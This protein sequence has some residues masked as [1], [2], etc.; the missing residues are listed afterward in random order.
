MSSNEKNRSLKRIA[1]VIVLAAAAAALAM[2]FLPVAVTDVLA[3]TEM[4]S[5]ESEAE[6]RAA[7]EPDRP[8]TV[9]VTRALSRV[10]NQSRAVAG[11]VEPARTVDIAFQIPGQVF[12]LDVEAGDR[13]LKGDVI[14]KLDQADFELAV[15]R[16]QASF[17]LAKTEFDRASSLAQR[18]VAADARLDTARAQFAQADVALRESTRRLSQTQIT[19][20]FDAI[21]A[22]TFVEEYVNVTSAAPV[23]RLQDVSEMRI[24]ISLPEEL[25]AVAR[26]SPDA[27]DI[28][29]SFPAVPGFNA[30]LVPRSFATDADPT[31]QTY[32]VEFAITGDIDQR[33]LPGMT[34]DVRISTASK[35][36]PA[37]SVTVPVSAVDTTSR[38]D[39]SVWIYE[40]ASG[41]VAR[42]TVRLGLPVNDEVVVLDGLQGNEMV[43]SGGWWRLRD[44]QSVTVSGL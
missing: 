20:P 17:D 21:V 39:P 14:A 29:A 30:P 6:T 5:G 12:S 22:R 3:Q 32:D 16:A 25:A 7:P 35:E 33:L 11:R 24:I 38:T 2:P 36:S 13:I 10:V 9:E 43:V 37:R 23:S 27:F 42:R 18:G 28:I 1:S 15:D 44:N 34:A 41:Q 8:V 40:E 19:A 26:S 4:A 31:A